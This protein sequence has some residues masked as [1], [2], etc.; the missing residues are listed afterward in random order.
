[1]KRFTLTELLV[2]IAFMAIL[3]SM[4]IPAL[5]KSRNAV[6]AAVCMNNMKQI[7]IGE[8]LSIKD[9]SGKY[10][11]AWDTSEDAVWDEVIC[12]YLGVELPDYSEFHYYFKEYPEILPQMQEFLLCPIDE[13]PLKEGKEGRA[14]RTYSMNGYGLDG[15][16]DTV[17]WGISSR[18]SSVY[19]SEVEEPS[20]TFTHLEQPSSS[21][22]TGGA[23]HNSAVS[24][25]GWQMNNSVVDDLSFH[26][27]LIFNYHFADGSVRAVNVWKAWGGGRY[28]MWDR[29]KE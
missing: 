25:Y 5:T 20:M 13:I 26:K 21:N 29:F 6:K 1:M 8:Q 18:N 3:I 14:R 10:T 15:T 28:G 4:L 23:G 11:E 16:T 17:R 24:V 22:M 7:G 12:Q 27:P 9:R 2:V 19:A